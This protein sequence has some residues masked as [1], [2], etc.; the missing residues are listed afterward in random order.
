MDESF[1]L[2]IAANSSV[3]KTEFTFNSIPKV[4]DGKNQFY[5]GDRVVIIFPGT[6]EIDDIKK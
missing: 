1:T 5:I 2:T 3:F 6:Y 4:T